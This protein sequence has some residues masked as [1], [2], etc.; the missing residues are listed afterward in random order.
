MFLYNNIS[1]YPILTLDPRTVALGHV[2]L[3]LRLKLSV[4]PLHIYP[5]RSHKP[6]FNAR[7]T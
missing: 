6:A 4:S 2:L 5:L 1:G 7:L 3:C